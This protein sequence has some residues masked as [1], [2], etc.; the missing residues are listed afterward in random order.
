MNCNYLDENDKIVKSIKS[1]TFKKKTTE[2]RPQPEAVHVETDAE[3]LQYAETK[4]LVFNLDMLVRIT[5]YDKLKNAYFEERTPNNLNN[6]KL[7]FELLKDMFENRHL[8][9]RIKKRSTVGHISLID[10]ALQL[11]QKHA[12]QKTQRSR[13]HSALH[14][15]PQM[16]SRDLEKIE[17]LNKWEKLKEESIG[18]ESLQEVLD[19]LNNNR[20]RT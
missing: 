20:V 19:N 15:M 6:L 11:K 18:S 8:Y 7:E 16:S 4:D 14:Q 12:T 10:E 13:L 17:V 1:Y 5:N 2:K 3:K 9:W